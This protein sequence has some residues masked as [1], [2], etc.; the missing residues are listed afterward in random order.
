ML[1]QLHLLQPRRKITADIL[2]LTSICSKV[3]VFKET[4]ITLAPSN[5]Q[6]T[7]TLS[8]EGIACCVGYGAQEMAITRE[9]TIQVICCKGEE[10]YQAE[11]LISR[12][13]SV[14]RKLFCF[15]SKH[16]FINGKKLKNLSSKLWQT[17]FIKDLLLSLHIRS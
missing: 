4:F 17:K 13:E 1:L 16:G 10:V 7:L 9:R 12:A 8:T 11:L 2:T 15:S 14:K 3:I 6:L 5:A